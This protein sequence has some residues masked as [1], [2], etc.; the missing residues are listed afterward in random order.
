MPAMP[1]ALQVHTVEGVLDVWRIVDDSMAKIRADAMP[2]SDIQDFARSITAHTSIWG[3]VLPLIP[4]LR[5]GLQG[6]NESI[7]SLRREVGKLGQHP[8]R[9]YPNPLGHHF[10]LFRTQRAEARVRLEGLLPHASETQKAL[11]EELTE[12]WGELLGESLWSSP[13]CAAAG[14]VQ[15]LGLIG[16]GQV[17]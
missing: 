14:D 8:T 12:S 1:Q 11:I 3:T 10:R 15:Q 5:S 2:F 7:E 13:D 9:R 4:E 16:C 6:D 17:C